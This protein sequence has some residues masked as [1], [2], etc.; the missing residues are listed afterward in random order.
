[1]ADLMAGGS[2]VTDA[3]RKAGYKG[4]A[5]HA[6]WQVTQ[7]KA[8]KAYY[9]K[10]KRAASK[11]AKEATEQAVLDRLGILRAMSS[12]V[13]GGAGIKASERVQAATLLCKAEGY[14]A[15]EESHVVNEHKGEVKTVAEMVEEAQQ[16]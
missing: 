15:P 5:L 7:G 14:F 12:I 8:F 10:V 3:Y 16:G 2:A 6:S 1:M 11:K 4:K 13:E 9:A